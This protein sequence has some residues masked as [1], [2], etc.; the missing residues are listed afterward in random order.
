MAGFYTDCKGFFYPRIYV[1]KGNSEHPQFLSSSLFLFSVV[2][3]TEWFGVVRTETVEAV[4]KTFSHVYPNCLMCDH[5]T[6][7][8]LPA[9]RGLEGTVIPQADST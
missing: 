8:C 9:D 4:M 5:L 7:H 2:K 1:Y 3:P 6:T